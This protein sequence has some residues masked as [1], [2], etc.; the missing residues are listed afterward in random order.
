MHPGHVQR[1][2]A[3][4]RHIL[5]AGSERGGHW[6]PHLPRY[7][8]ES[9][10]QSA[11]QV[12]GAVV[13]SHGRGA[14]PGE[15]LGDEAEADWILGG[16]SS[17]KAHAGA[18]ELPEA[19]YLQGGGESGSMRSKSTCRSIV[20]CEAAAALQEAAAALQDAAVLSNTCWQPCQS[21]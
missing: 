7:D 5:T 13:E 14:V 16:L 1:H 11:S 10:G 8:H 3:H 19:A 15:E 21:R 17:C 20:S 9:K 2:A 18:Q 4:H 6:R 12:D